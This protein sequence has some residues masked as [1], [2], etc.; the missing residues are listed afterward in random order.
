M[1][2]GSSTA[3]R[4]QHVAL[5]FGLWAAVVVGGCVMVGPDD[6]DVI[7]TTESSSDNGLQQ[8]LL[9]GL[10]QGMA[11]GLSQGLSQ[12]L[13]QGL[14]QGLAQG[15][16]QGLNQ[17]LNQ[18]LAQGLSQGL[19]QGLAQGLSQGLSQGLNAGLFEA[20]TRALE[21]AV[22][23]DLYPGLTQAAADDLVA[24]MNGG[25]I[26][27]L[28][29][30]VLGGRMQGLNA[31]MLDGIRAGYFHH[32][33]V[34]IAG[35][36]VAGWDPAVAPEH[37]AVAAWI[38]YQIA[39]IAAVYVASGNDVDVALDAGAMIVKY[40]FKC[41]FPSPVT[42]AWSDVRV[43]HQASWTYGGQYGSA[44]VAEK[45]NFNDY[46]LTCMYQTVNISGYMNVVFSNRDVVMAQRENGTDLCDASDDDM[47]ADEDG[48]LCSASLLAVVG[49]PCVLVTSDVMSRGINDLQERRMGSE[50]YALVVDSSTFVSS[51]SVAGYQ[52]CNCASRRA[53]T[54][55]AA[56]APASG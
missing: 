23:D 7:R 27:G 14:N 5:A 32:L 31:R 34:A 21:V 45:P 10:N 56:A 9:Q 35:G 2:K 46:L 52:D 43:G 33:I 26:Q 29:A 40:E 48:L 51:S 16:M 1:T 47:T 25:L 37:Y 44:L 42:F 39:G 53:A 30:A 12:G 22:A 55:G 13:A 15:L 28:T 4:T 24:A 50:F 8:G 54:T 41:L 6:E 19:S 18:G 36:Q 38:A 3:S 20:L 17:G 49:K 11:Q